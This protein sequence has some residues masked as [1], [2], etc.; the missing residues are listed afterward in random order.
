MESEFW[1]ARWERGEIGFH[2]DE[3]NPHLVRFWPTLGIPST[4]PVFVPLCGKSRD[5][6]WLR[7]RGHAVW[8]VELSPLAVARFF[9]EHGLK[10]RRK[11]VRDMSLFSADGC[12]I[13][14]GDFFRLRTKHFPALHAVY[15]RASLIALPPVMRQRYVRHLQGLVS[16]G[17]RALLISVDYPAHQMQGPPFAVDDQE[18]H[19]LF[20]AGFDIRSLSALNVLDA[21][22]RFRERGLTRIEERVY[23]LTRR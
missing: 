17:T 12:N 14:R 6:V 20:E 15:D 16:S 3:T 2:Q 19:T 5:M 9:E 18:V 1:M 21:N 23:A 22:P 7:D 4:V 8:G 10:P 13:Y 11:M